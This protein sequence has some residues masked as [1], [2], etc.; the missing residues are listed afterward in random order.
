MNCLVFLF[1]L[2]FTKFIFYRFFINVKFILTD[3]CNYQ[4]VEFRRMIIREFTFFFQINIF[5]IIKK[6]NK[7]YHFD[8]IKVYLHLLFSIPFFS[9]KD[10]CQ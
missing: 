4:S 10:I 5:R 8:Y 6:E 7:D 3:K 2:F 1:L 9:H